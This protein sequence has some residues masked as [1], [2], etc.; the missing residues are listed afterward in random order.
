[1]ILPT[2]A[3]MY[4]LYRKMDG[5]IV[6]QYFDQDKVYAMGNSMTIKGEWKD[7]ETV[8]EKSKKE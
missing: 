8:N 7:L 6:L 1:M 4:R 2:D 3:P 5:E